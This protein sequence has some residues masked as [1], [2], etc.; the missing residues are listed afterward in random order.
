MCIQFLTHNIIMQLELQGA[1]M[2]FKNLQIFQI[3]EPIAYDGEALAVQLENDRHKPCGKLAP[4]SI[5]WVAPIETSPDSPLV[6]ATNGFMLLALN[7]EEKV[8]PSQVLREQVALRVA[9]IAEREG[10]KVRKKE[11]DML[12]DEVYAEL[13]IKAFTKSSRLFAYIDTQENYLIINA[14]SRN[15]AELFLEYLRKS[16]NDIKLIEPELASPVATMTKWVQEQNYPDNIVIED[17]CVLEDSKEEGATIRIKG[18]DL[19]ADN[20]Q[21][22]FQDGYFVSQLGMSWTEQV[23]FVLTD[24]FIFKSLKFLEAL[25]DQVNDIVS[26]TEQDRFDADFFIMTQVIRELLQEMFACFMDSDVEKT[27]S[28]TA[29]EAAAV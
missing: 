1:N 2:W 9:E 12:K 8:I 16:L 11:K 21:A 20:V 26:E 19:F 22:F 15:K 13:L 18:Q 6:H 17:V 25:Q 10:R 27:A 3:A 14:A 28:I 7:I 24:G 29:E 5:G 23:R 4:M